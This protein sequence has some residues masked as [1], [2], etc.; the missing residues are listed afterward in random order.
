MASVKAKRYGTAVGRSDAS[1]GAQN[2]Y[3]RAE[4]MGR[5]PTH[6]NVHAQAE[7]VSGRLG[8]EHLWSDGQLAGRARSM[9]RH[10]AQL[11]ALSLQHRRYIDDVNGKTPCL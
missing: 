9:S 2:Q 3:F 7:E 11:Q 6:A 5:I 8:Q 4:D 10:R 1:M